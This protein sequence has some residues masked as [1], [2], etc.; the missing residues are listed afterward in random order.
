MTAR[1]AKAWY[2]GAREARGG[3]TVTA[4]PTLDDTALREIVTDIV[5]TLRPEGVIGDSSTGLTIASADDLASGS[6]AP[7]D[8]SLRNELAALDIAGGKEGSIFRDAIAE[9]QEIRVSSEEAAGAV[10]DHAERIEDFRSYM[11]PEVGDN[12]ADSVSAIF[13]ACHFQDLTGQRISKVTATLRHIE[14]RVDRIR[15]ALDGQVLEPVEDP[16]LKAY[17]GPGP[18]PTGPQSRCGAMTQADVDALLEGDAA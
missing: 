14:E 13:Q 17:Y 2:V 16:H 6:N 12:I 5:R 8:D 4:I 7:C 11:A 15:Q 9:L 3:E 1:T 10:L 18:R